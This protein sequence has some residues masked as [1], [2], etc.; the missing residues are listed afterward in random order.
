MDRY[1]A[2]EFP[3]LKGPP[4]QP[5]G[6]VMA[7]SLRHVSAVVGESDVATGGS[8]R[9]GRDAPGFAVPMLR[10]HPHEQVGGRAQ[11]LF[12]PQFGDALG[13]F[14]RR[15]FQYFRPVIAG[16]GQADIRFEILA[17]EPHALREMP[18]ENN[19]S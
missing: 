4:R 11:P 3:I 14:G 9:S 5:C 12:P 18:S 6:E 15:D 2:D 10:R 17:A 8:F 1:F 19:C 13:V 7:T 16:A